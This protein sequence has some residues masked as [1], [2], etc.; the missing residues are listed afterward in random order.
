MMQTKIALATLLM[1]YTFNLNEK[2]EIP[3]KM[4][5]NTPSFGPEG[6]VWLNV[7]KI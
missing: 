3:L 7:Q 4:N 5:A 1:N 6:S 2:T